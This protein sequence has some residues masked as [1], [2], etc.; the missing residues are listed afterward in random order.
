MLTLMR[1]AIIVA[2]IFLLSPVRQPDSADDRRLKREAERLAGDM[3]GALLT[4]E[5]FGRERLPVL[6]GVEAPPEA[7]RGF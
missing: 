7:K 6:L 3:A 4:A 1:I 2:A 5:S